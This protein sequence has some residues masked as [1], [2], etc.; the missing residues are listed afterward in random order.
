MGKQE[1]RDRL[2]VA[3]RA[4]SQ[5]A[6][7]AAGDAIAEHLL[8]APEMRRVG[9]VAAYVSVGT[10]PPTDRLLERLRHQGVG[11]LLPV[12]LPDLDLAWGEYA[13]AHSLEHGPRGMRQPGGQRLAPNAVAGVDAVLCP[14]LAVDGSGLRLGRGGGSYDRVL[15]RVAPAVWSCV[16][17]YAHEVLDA[18]LPA[19]AHDQRVG[20]AATPEGIVRFTPRR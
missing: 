16:L 8:T 12:L 14:G 19:D 6:R 3:R 11:V 1:M 9:T 20:A 7:A 18:D 10:E 13:G 17:L 4:R 5:Q 15:A 2:L